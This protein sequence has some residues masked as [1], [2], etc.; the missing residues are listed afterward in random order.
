MMLG[1]VSPE[2]KKHQFNYIPLCP[3]GKALHLGNGWKYW[4]LNGKYQYLCTYMSITIRI[5][6]NTICTCVFIKIHKK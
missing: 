5:F 4:D 3:N 2:F 6:D 1:V